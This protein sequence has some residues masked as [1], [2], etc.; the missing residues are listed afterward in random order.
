VRSGRAEI[1]LYKAS[2][3]CNA[4]HAMRKMTLPVLLASLLLVGCATTF[5]N[6]TPQKQVRSPDNS[7]PVEVAFNTRQQ[8]LRW[9][10]IKPSVAID[11]KFLP[12]RPT[13]LMTNRWE[14]FVP[15]T[16]GTNLVRYYYKFDFEYNDFGGPRTDSAI[17]P[18]YQLQILDR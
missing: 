9:E 13:P 15:V 6:L 8:S 1:Q 12:M 11:G 18:E 16:A 2:I 10:S 5:T 3:L 17:S 7:Y 4:A 14:G